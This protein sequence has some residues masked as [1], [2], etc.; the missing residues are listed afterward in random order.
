MCVHACR[1]VGKFT[2]WTIC[3]TPEYIAPEIVANQG[4]HLGVDWWA[5]GITI[6]EMLTGVPPFTGPT[7]MEVYQQ[8]LRCNLKL[9][10]E[11]SPDAKVLIQQV[12]FRLIRIFLGPSGRDSCHLAFPFSLCLQ[13]LRVKSDQRFGCRGRGAKDV[14]AH[15]F[16]VTLDWIAL[17]ARAP[18][19]P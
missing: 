11:L 16:F 9:P 13:L 7:Q 1:Y 8:V 19:L 10:S 18:A 15:D 12:C 3:G 6:H 5:L 4:H 2:T 14:M 17:E